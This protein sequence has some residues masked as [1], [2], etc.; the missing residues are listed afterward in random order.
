ML[1]LVACAAALL[2]WPRVPVRDRLRRPGRDVVVR[3]GNWPL[4]AGMAALGLVLAGPAGG[5][6][7]LA[8]SAL[9]A[10]QRRARRAG[11]R[12]LRHADEL[13]EA[14]RLLVAQ[15]RSGAH[16]AVAAA[17]AAAEAGPAVAGPFGDLAATARLGGEVTSLPLDEAPPDLRASLGRLIRAWALAERHGVALADLLD[18][19]R[20]DL[21]R[22]TAF[23]REVD[24][25]LAG[26]RATAAVLTGLPLLGLLFGEAMGARPL[27]VLSGGLSGQLVLLTGTAL[28]AAG[29]LWS[30]RLTGSVVR[31]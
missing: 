24:A 7:G 23:R 13:A 28:L 17:D 25:K 12:G 31:P 14:L 19:V 6:A 4:P 11:E 5:V 8:G 9:V 15:L 1:S 29:V 26:P 2:C 27:E 21:E 16:P 22:R 30:E 3:F 10:R 18:S 20:R